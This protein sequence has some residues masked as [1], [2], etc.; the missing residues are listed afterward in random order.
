MVEV[1]LLASVTIL[2]AVVEVVPN[3]LLVRRINLEGDAPDA[4]LA[5]VVGAVRL[6]RLLL[7][8]GRSDERNNPAWP[9]GRAAVIV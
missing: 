1:N 3:L 2:L 7:P 9:L 8:V 6:A 5:L 4:K